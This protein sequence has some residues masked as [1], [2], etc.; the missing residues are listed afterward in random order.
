[1]L[2]PEEVL[3]VVAAV[4][5]VTDFD[6]PTEREGSLQ[7]FNA[8][9][10]SP[11]PKYITRWRTDPSLNRD[12]YV[13][14]IR[15]IQTFV[16][17]GLAAA[18]YHVQRLADLE[19][20]VAKLLAEF[21]SE[22]RYTGSIGVGPTRI[23]DFEY[24]AFILAYRRCLDYLA[25]ALACYF[26]MN[27]RSFR[28]F[29]KSLAK[30]NPPAVS[31]ALR[32]AHARH[33][34]ALAFVLLDG[35]QSIRNRIAHYEFVPAGFIN[36]NSRYGVILIGGGEELHK[37]L[38]KGSVTLSSV[39]VARLDALHACVDDMI[40]TFMSAVREH[41]LREDGQVGSGQR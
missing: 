33:V 6:I 28:T 40:D 35:R 21:A 27:V 3:R 2:K 18:H 12:W 32:K 11:E 36:L 29:P 14:H 30:T 15:G 4:R 7:R 9:L 5:T 22:T 41:E 25:G 1:M 39:L 38:S 16:R 8:F 17:G 19:T 23:L 24:Q 37:D 31:D 26:K 34:D 20:A 10:I 13:P